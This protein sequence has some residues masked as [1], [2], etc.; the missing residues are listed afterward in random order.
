MNTDIGHYDQLPSEIEH[1]PARIEVPKQ[2]QNSESPVKQRAALFEK[3]SQHDAMLVYEMPHIHDVRNPAKIRGMWPPEQDATRKGKVCSEFVTSLEKHHLKFHHGKDEPLVKDNADSPPSISQPD[4]LRMTHVPP[5]P[6]TLPQLVSPR[7]RSRPDITAVGDSFTTFP[8]T[9]YNSAKVP[10]L[11]TPKSDESNV[12]GV[13]SYNWA[14]KWDVFRKSPN[15]PTKESS[16][17]ARA[18]PDHHTSP[19]KTHATQHRVHDLLVAAQE[20]SKEPN[21]EPDSD[22]QEDTKSTPA[23]P[24]MPGALADTPRGS[25]AAEKE[26][27]SQSS[28]TPAG[29]ITPS[30]PRGRHRLQDLE[31]IRHST[32]EEQDDNYKVEQRFAL[33]R[34]RSRGGGV[35][36]QVE[37][38]SPTASPERGGEHIVILTANVA[39]R[40]E[41]DEGA[42]GTER[43]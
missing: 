40:N 38:R 19:K 17:E 15:A 29:A 8:Q 18:E 24:P 33:G 30:T 23:R 32:A 5:I 37:I 22:Q 7:R 42:N 2:T 39:P 20:A 31:V 26:V 41:Q 6:L 16:I 12:K 10:I 4:R 21:S 36:V 9:K 14:L 35:R 28:M 27:A 1:E 34:S 25:S 43:N 13:T 3:L 11:S